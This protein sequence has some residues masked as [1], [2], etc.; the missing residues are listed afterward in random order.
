M[1]IRYERKKNVESESQ[2]FESYSDYLMTMAEK[3]K[4]AYEHN[5]DAL[6]SRY[7][8]SAECAEKAPESSKLWNRNI[9]HTD[10]LSHRVGLG[11]LPFQA[12]I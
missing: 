12:E 6:L 8:S 9:S 2:R 1:N 11:E 5:T 7:P 4:S 3:V 10:F